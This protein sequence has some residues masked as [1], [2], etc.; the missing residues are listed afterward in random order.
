MTQT[1]TIKKHLKKH[2]T[3]TVMEAFMKYGIT[4]LSSRIC[5]L[6]EEGQ[7]IG[8]YWVDVKNRAGEV[9]RVKRYY[10]GRA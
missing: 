6:K 8:G 4:S 10:V 9:V 5:E 7:K 1:E 3:I 2:K